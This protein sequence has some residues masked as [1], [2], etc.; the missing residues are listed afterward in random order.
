MKIINSKEIDLIRLLSLELIKKN[1][2]EN[3][4][5]SYNKH[6]FKY[7]HLYLENE[8]RFRFAIWIE[9]ERYFYSSMYNPYRFVIF[10]NDNCKTLDVEIIDNN[11]ILSKKSQIENKEVENKLKEIIKTINNIIKKEK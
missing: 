3:F 7:E 6:R 8:I 10:E 11:F 9:K 2:N 1:K 5:I 4:E